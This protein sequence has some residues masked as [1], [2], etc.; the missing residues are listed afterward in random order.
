MTRHSPPSA[1]QSTPASERDP[2]TTPPAIALVMVNFNGL[3]HLRRCLPALRATLTAPAKVVVVDNGSSDGSVEWLAS[4]A[5]WVSCLPLPHNVGFG[6]ANRVGIAATSSALVALL[7]NDTEPQP[8]WLEA[9]LAPLA[10]DPT[11]AAS[12][13]QLRL[14]CDP[15][16]LNAHGGGMS[17]LGFGFDRQLHCPTAAADGPRWSECLFPTAAALVMRRAAFEAVGGFDRAFFMY[18]DDVDLGW[19]FW[20]AGWR[21]VVCRDAVVLHA[22]GGSTALEFRN[23]LGARH[24]VRSMLKN[25]G[26]RFAVAKPIRL[27][28]LWVAQRQYALLRHVAWWNLLHL[29][30]TLIARW[31]IQRSRRVS[32]A[33]LLEQG[34]IDAAPMPPPFP[35][36]AR[37]VG[38]TAAQLATRHTLEPAATSSIGRLGPGWYARE[39]VGG[40]WR[41]RTCGHASCVLRVEPHAQGTLRV[42]VSQE[43]PLRAKV[44]VNANGASAAGVCDGQGAA[45]LVLAVRADADGMVHVEIGS[46]VFVPHVVKGNWDFRRNGCIVDSVEFSPNEAVSKPS[47]AS[48]SVVIPTFNRREHL[49]LVLAALDAQGYPATEIIVVDDGSTDDTW[50]LLQAWQ[51]KTGGRARRIA[52]HQENLRPGR[53]RNRGLAEATGDLIVF[54]GDDTIPDRDFLAAHVARHAATRG[55]LAVIGFTDWD[56]ARIQVTPFL[57]FI[58]SDG[59]QF[60]YGIIDERTE[61]PFNCFYTSNVSV[62]R[63][64]LG[65]EPF[66]ARFDFVGWEDVDLGYRLN[67]AGVPLVYEPKACTR[68]VHPTTVNSF[69]RRQRGVG[70]NFPVLYGVHPRVLEEGELYPPHIPVRFRVLVPSFAALRPL[71]SGLDRAGVQ[72]PINVYRTFVACAFFS[73]MRGALRRAARQAR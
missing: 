19:R 49:A 54:L 51:S 67:L 11:V 3:H 10:A 57:E 27:A 23:R 55:P 8:G 35:V 36:L 64:L 31:H 30:S 29:P 15:R 73:G 21:V 39:R 17:H 47:R 44:V 25:Y 42:R 68:H 61:L 16:T 14:I 48:V 56:R 58:N 71:L 7:N 12:C 22:R 41:R 46:P 2:T 65:D 40:V 34:L 13:A 6:E 50:G 69:W 18:H 32:D 72:M 24:A 9:L 70:A 28:R 66:D 52:V 4:A 38:V 20:L 63:A 60:A 1:E 62:P 37:D 43:H 45:E 53:A 33:H 26:F 5:P 59:P